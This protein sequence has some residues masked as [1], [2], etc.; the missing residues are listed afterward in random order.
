MF[1]GDTKALDHAS[2]ISLCL[3]QHSPT[4]GGQK[5]YPADKLNLAK[6]NNGAPND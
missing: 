2:R 4:W 5:E 6:Q 1:S 3:D